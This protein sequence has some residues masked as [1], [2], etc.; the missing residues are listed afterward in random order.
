IGLPPSPVELAACVVDEA[1]PTVDVSSPPAPPVPKCKVS[2]E[3]EQAWIAP[4]VQSVT[5]GAATSSQREAIG[6]SMTSKAVR[7][8]YTDGALGVAWAPGA[9]T[10]PR[11][12]KR[13]VRRS[14]FRGTARCTLDERRSVHRRAAPQA[15]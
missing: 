13:Y 4:S 7:V 10:S 5:S 9:D 15:A 6:T 11:R 12:R 14:R 1:P 8:G 3:A 2:L